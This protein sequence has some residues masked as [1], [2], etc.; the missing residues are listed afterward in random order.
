M[1]GPSNIANP[2]E[3]IAVSIRELIAAAGE[4]AFEYAENDND[5]RRLA[6]IALIEFLRTRSYSEN[7]DR[8]FLTPTTGHQTIH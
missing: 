6:R 7:V 2:K 5:G 4:L 8:D 3:E 1:T